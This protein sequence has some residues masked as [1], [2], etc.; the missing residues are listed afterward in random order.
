MWSRA[1][2]ERSRK[3]RS[4]WKSA[5]AN[6]FQ[7][8][9]KNILTFNWPACTSSME[10]PRSSIV[11]RVPLCAC[12]RNVSR[13]T[14]VPLSLRFS[15]WFQH[16]GTPPPYTNDIHQYLNVTFGQHWIGV[17]P[18]SQSNPITMLARRTYHDWT[19]SAGVK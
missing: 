11:T 9:R 1:L 17:G 15:V 10:L 12:T 8:S 4:R 6:R 13:D 14:H 19:S 3:Q 7:G 18:P 2:N 5:F 16:G